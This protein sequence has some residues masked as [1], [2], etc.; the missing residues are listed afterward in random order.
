MTTRYRALRPLAT[1]WREATCAEVD[2]PN[3]LF[4]WKTILPAT[5]QAN[6]ALIRRSGLSF[7]EEPD[8]ALVAFI[9]EP[10][11]TCFEGMAK[12]H[13]TRLERDPI[14]LRNREKM[15]P[16]QWIE[17]MNDHLYKFGGKN[18]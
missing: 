10:G 1:H 3:H 11:Q 14:F 17:N 5:D 2:C 4:G 18:G 16:L 7:K 8:G 13:R 9:F 15:A 6:L 12:K